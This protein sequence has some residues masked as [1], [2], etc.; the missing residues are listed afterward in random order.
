MKQAQAAATAKYQ[1][2]EALASLPVAA[3]AADLTE[4]PSP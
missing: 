4:T 1:Q 3:P 2:Y